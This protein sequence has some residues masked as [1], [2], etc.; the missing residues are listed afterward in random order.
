MNS[1][2]RS[3]VVLCWS[4]AILLATTQAWFTRFTMNPDG[5]SYLDMGDYFWSGNF[6]YFVNGY[7]SPIYPVIL[8][9]FI[10]IFHPSAYWEYPL[11]HFVNLLIFIAVLPCFEFFLRTFIRE[12]ATESL[13]EWVLRL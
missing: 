1:R 6:Q 4:L 5:V 8:G 9:A 10:K 11:A 2:H 12:Y 3:P 7:W 13:P